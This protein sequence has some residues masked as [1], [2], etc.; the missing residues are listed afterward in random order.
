MDWSK[1]K[2][3]LIIAFIVTNLLLA[4]VVFIHKGEDTSY[5]TVQE[6]FIEDVKKLLAKKDIQVDCEIPKDIST[7]SKISIEYEVY[8][9]EKI[10]KR[11]LGNYKKIEKDKDIYY[12]NEK[13]TLR[14]VSNKKIVYENKSNNLS[15]YKLNKEL[16]Q[17]IVKDFLKNKGFNTDD[18]KLSNYKEKN[19]K[20]ILEYTKVYKGIL[21][22][23]SYM[24]FQIDKTGIK[25]FER[26]WINVTGE[27]KEN[28]NLETRPIIEPAPEVLLRLLS[29]KD[30]YGKTITDIRLCYYFPEKHSIGDWKSTVKGQTVPA[31]R[32]K[33][34]D[35]TVVFLE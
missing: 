9:P 20:Y 12:Q 25:K 29:Q 8:E 4:Y 34:K 17:S 32:I 6:G 7:M 11:F 19:G 23:K 13:E 33:F 22:E 1:A 10:A 15:F 2:T 21:V 18:F 26:F 24:T 16:T 3:V 14:V 30:L 28:L 35:G 5:L 27:N 31:W